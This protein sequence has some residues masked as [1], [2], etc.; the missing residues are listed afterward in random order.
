MR[1]IKLRGWDKHEK[2]WLYFTLS[3]LCY[4]S[5]GGTINVKD[6][7]DLVDVDDLEWHLY[8]GLLDKNGKEIWEGD[9][10]GSITM[11]EIRDGIETPTKRNFEIFWDEYKFR[12][13]CTHTVPTCLTFDMPAKEA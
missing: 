13:R 6:W 4:K 10:L 12:L 9:V 3:D 2:R 1:E 8:T 7:D 11:Y 5:D